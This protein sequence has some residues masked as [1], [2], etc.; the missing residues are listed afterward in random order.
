LRVSTILLACFQLID[1]LAELPVLFLKRTVIR[2]PVKGAGAE[3]GISL[4]PVDADFARGVERSD[5]QAQLDG[6]QLD[7]EQVDLNVA[8]DHQ[9][10]VEHPLQDVAK[11]GRVAAATVTRTVDLCGLGAGLRNAS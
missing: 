1:S 9:A 10:L 6:K 5:H 11:V 7:V 8:R 3:P 4:P 2:S